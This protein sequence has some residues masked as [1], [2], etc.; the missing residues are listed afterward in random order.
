S[1]GMPPGPAEPWKRSGQALAKFNKLFLS[2][3]NF[4]WRPNPKTIS[5]PPAWHTTRRGRS[6]FD[7]NISKALT[8]RWLTN[9]TDPDP[10]PFN[11]EKFYTLVGTFLAS[12]GK[13]KIAMSCGTNDRIFS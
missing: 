12:D 11:W 10:C 2:K 8:S 4:F 6:P 7:Y 5:H 3:E 9:W 13:N 1:P